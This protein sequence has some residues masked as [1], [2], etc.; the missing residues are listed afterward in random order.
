MLRARD[1]FTVCILLCVIQGTNTDA[2]CFA[3]MYLVQLSSSWVCCNA[4]WWLV[5]G[6]HLVKKH[7]DLE[8]Q[9]DQRY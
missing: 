6:C 4:S 5:Y 7:I 9:K 8:I 3:F 1:I 2:F